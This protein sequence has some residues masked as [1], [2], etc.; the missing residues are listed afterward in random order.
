M[1]QFNQIIIKYLINLHVDPPTRLIL[2]HIQCMNKK[3]DNKYC[4]E[5]FSDDAGLLLLLDYMLY[6]AFSRKQRE[7]EKKWQI[8]TKRRYAKKKRQ[9]RISWHLIVSR[10][11]KKLKCRVYPMP[12]IC[13]HKTL[14]LSVL[15]IFITFIAKKKKN[16]EHIS[17]IISLFLFFFCRCLGIFFAYFLCYLWGTYGSSREG[18]FGKEFQTIVELFW[19]WIKQWFIWIPR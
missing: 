14:K 2:S 7:N 12:S 10:G 6:F 4:R 18:I 16:Y 9:Q 15:Q 1:Q 11:K 8:I 13:L 5:L 3:K 19:N 17:R